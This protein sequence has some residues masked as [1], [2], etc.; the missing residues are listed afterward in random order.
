MNTETYQK[1]NEISEKISKYERDILDM[2]EEISQS[3]FECLTLV[4]G[5]RIWTALNNDLLPIPLNQ[6]LDQYI[7]TGESKIKELT[8]QFEQL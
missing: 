1:A 4:S 7:A 8:S 6:F 2:K 5:R 3:R